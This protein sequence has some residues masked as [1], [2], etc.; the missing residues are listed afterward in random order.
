M[1]T[2]PEGWATIHRPTSLSLDSENAPSLIYYDSFSK[3]WKEELCNREQRRRRVEV[4]A[5][6]EREGDREREG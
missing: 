3:L 5:A 4:S 2:I 1:S 6:K